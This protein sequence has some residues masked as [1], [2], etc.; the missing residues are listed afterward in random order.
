MQEYQSLWNS[1]RDEL[2]NQLAPSTFEETFGKVKRT[3]KEENGLIYIICPNT[4]TKFK[5][6]QV[7]Y[8]SIE[9]IL[10]KITSRQVKFKFVLD[11]EIIEKKQDSIDIPK[12]SVNNLNLNYTFESFVV[13]ES[14][15]RSWL[16]A[17]K[18]AEDPGYF[19][20]PL[21][22][23]GSVGLGKTHLMQAIGNFISEMHIDFKI[24]YIQAQEYFSDYTKACAD[25]NFEAFEKKYSTI[26]VLLVDDIQMLE[27]K[28]STQEQF[29]NLFNEMINN[30]KQVVITSDRPASKLNGFMDR[31]TSRFNSGIVVDINQ[32]DFNQ[33]VSILKKKAEEMTA[34]QIN[35]DV[36]AYIAENF[37]DNVR[38]LEG[39]LN[40]VIRMSELFNAEPNL[41]FAKDELQVL[42]KVKK[43][44]EDNNYE[45]A[46]SVISDMY[47][48]P[49]ADMLGKSRQ[50]KYVTPRHISMYILKTKYS[51]TL[52]QI[53]SIFSCHHTS[54]M[55][56]IQKIEKEQ[57]ENEELKLAIETVLKKIGG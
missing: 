32:P 25:K 6:N 7:Y 12:I 4:V 26:D 18:V 37:T 54:V 31:L 50:E 36:L 8:K 51:L 13:G 2:K 35:D 30:N 3:A 40:R 56:G 22:I 27:K 19:V 52:Q 24:L 29:F 47:S 55:S 5:I 1:V 33:R 42:I 15:K 14:N 21:Y 38:E 9:G 28:V 34:K 44:K 43:P 16:T 20:N 39:A 10:K 11:E 49:Q 57:E 23:F 17:T 48:I 46:L 41:Q 53:A 45:N